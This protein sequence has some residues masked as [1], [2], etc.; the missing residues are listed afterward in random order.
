ME[1]GNRIEDIEEAADL[2]RQ[3][4]ANHRLLVEQTPLDVKEAEGKVDEAKGKVDEIAADL[5]EL[6]VKAPEPS[7]VEVVSVRPGDL[8]A[9]NQPIIRVLRTGDLWIKVYMPET[10]LSHVRLNQE[11]AVTV[12]GYPGRRLKGRIEQIN[13]EAEF[14]PRNVQSVDERRHQVF[15]IRVFVADPEGILKS[16]MAAEVVIP[17]A[18]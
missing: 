16:G 15:G 5:R 13:A 3:A 12:D 10:N 14:T 7:L 11:V 1:A 17:L 6:E 2:W 4:Q 18:P 9:P 8:V